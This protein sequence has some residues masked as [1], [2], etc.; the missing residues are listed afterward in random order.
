AKLSLRIGWG[1]FLALLV[2][3]LIGYATFSIA[4]LV[5]VAWLAYYY[6]R[7]SEGDALR[8]AIVVA[9][10]LMTIFAWGQF[11]SE[12]EVDDLLKGIERACRPSCL[13]P[14]FD[15]EGRA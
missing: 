6:I 13:V 11:R 3:A 4:K 1:I 5:G 9:S 8:R 12:V 15:G 7:F 2:A 10:A 14:A